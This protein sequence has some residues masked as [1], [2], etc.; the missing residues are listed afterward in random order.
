MSEDDRHAVT[1]VLVH[2]TKAIAAYERQLVSRESAFDRFARGLASGDPQQ[3]SALSPSAQRGLKLF[4]TSA[5]CRQCHSDANF[6]DDEFHD[7]GLAPRGGGLRSDP[8]RYAGLERLLADPLRASGE[9]SDAREGAKA[10][11]LEFLPRTQESW[12]QFKTPSLR[13]VALTAPYSHDG[14]FATLE[15]VVRFYSTL[16]GSAPAGHH[17]ERVLQPL[18]LSEEAIADLVAFLE[19]L[20]DE[21][22]DKALLTAPPSPLLE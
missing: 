21:G 10:R 18:D 12:G 22:I 13:N 19:S 4:V 15:D 8:G 2:A 20:T 3:R 1:R 17:G 6:T 16:E 14:T 5:D 7:L 11:E 9:F